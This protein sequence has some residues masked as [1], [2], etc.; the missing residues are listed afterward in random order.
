MDT[1]ASSRE[2]T[3]IFSS[4]DV[5]SAVAST[6]IDA[7][8]ASTAEFFAVTLDSERELEALMELLG[9]TLPPSIPLPPGSDFS[10]LYDYSEQFLPVLTPDDFDAFYEKWLQISARYGNMDEYGQ[11]LF[12]ANYAKAWNTKA[13]RFILLEPEGAL[14]A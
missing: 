3:L 9:I 7:L 4:A 2:V 13:S 14:S 10:H 6:S 1:I 8:H 11:L 5:P 12:L